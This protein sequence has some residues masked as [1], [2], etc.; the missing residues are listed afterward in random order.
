MAEAAIQLY[1]STGERRYLESARTWV[2]TLDAQF[3]DQA[4]GGYYSTAHDAERMIIRTRIIFDQPAPSTNGT[5]ISLLTKLAL[6][7]GENDY[8]MRA[9]TVL[10][11]FAGEFSRNWISC[12]E[13][14][15]GFECFATGLQMVVVGKRNDART[16]ELLRAIWGKSMPN[17]LLVAVENTEELPANHPVFGKPMENGMPTVYLCQRNNCSEAYTSA[18]ALS[19]ALTLPQQPR[20]TVA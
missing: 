3:W 20:G 4:R 6:L 12:G 19:Q 8:G 15:N 13:F 11:A 7:T 5:M 9:Q 14:L 16:Q 18:V 2:R 10:Q 17:R 1:E